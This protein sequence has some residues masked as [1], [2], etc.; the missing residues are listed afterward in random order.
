M[1]TFIDSLKKSLT[2]YYVYIIIFIVS[3]VFI[4]VSYLVIQKY[5]Q[6]YVKNEGLMNDIA[7]ANTRKSTE[8]ATIMM[9]HVDWCP[10]C[11]TAKPGWDQFKAQLDGKVING[12]T[13]KCIDHNCTD[14]KDSKIQSLL[15]KYN[16][17]SYPTIKLLKRDEVLDFDSKITKSSLTSFV[18]T[19]L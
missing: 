12:F 7:N 17:E 10:H 13:L 15:N 9:F 4:I 11:K 8:T 2:P 19:M 1:P 6:T 5:K 14:D 18:N 3:I 16:I